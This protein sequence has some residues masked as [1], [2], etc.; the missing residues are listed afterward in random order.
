MTRCCWQE[1]W[2]SVENPSPWSIF[3][4]R[5]IA[6]GEDRARSGHDES[7]VAEPDQGEDSST[8]P[9]LRQ[10][11]DSVSDSFLHCLSSPTALAAQLTILQAPVPATPPNAG[12]AIDGWLFQAE[13][14][15]LKSH[16]RQ[17]A[18]ESFPFLW[19]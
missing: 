16:C 13:I 7:S 3:A 17:S 8:A 6:P 15:Q 5:I 4:D 18:A 10:T 14:A 12:D 11:L 1:E 19:V 2:Y 9:S